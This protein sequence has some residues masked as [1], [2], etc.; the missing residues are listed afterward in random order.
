MAVRKTT[1]LVKKNSASTNGAHETKSASTTPGHVKDMA[2]ALFFFTSR[3]V[4]R[5]A[6]RAPCVGFDRVAG[7]ATRM[8]EMIGTLKSLPQSPRSMLC[9]RI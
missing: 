7:T 5:T 9:F 1:R 2:L 8:P 3:V 4:L 6:M